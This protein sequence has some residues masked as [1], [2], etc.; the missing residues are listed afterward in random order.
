MED[1]EWRNEESLKRWCSLPFALGKVT[2]P[3]YG[4]PPKE[5]PHLNDY[6]VHC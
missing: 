6:N 2:Y 4:S 5:K 3:S 1:P